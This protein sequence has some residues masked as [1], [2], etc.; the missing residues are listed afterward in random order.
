MDCGRDPGA[1][2]LVILVL[3]ATLGGRPLLLPSFFCFH[4]TSVLPRRLP[5][6]L[7]DRLFPWV[8][9][10]SPHDRLLPVRDALARHGGPGLLRDGIS[11]TCLQCQY[12]SRH[13]DLLEM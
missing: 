3:C 13:S 11:R 6:S 1:K 4:V 10:L 2:A 8:P 5:G 9:T 7:L 12:G